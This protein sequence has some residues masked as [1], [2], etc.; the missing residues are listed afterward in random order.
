MSVYTYEDLSVGKIGYVEKTMTES[1]VNAYTGLTGDF[2]WLHVDEIRAKQG[3]FKARIVHGMFLA[4]LISNVVGNLMP[5]P[6]TCYVNQNMKFLK[7]C[8]INDTIKAQ[9]EVVEKLPRGRVKIKTTCYNQHGDI[10]L[11]GD[12]IVIPP[13]SEQA[14]NAESG[15]SS[16]G[17]E[18]VI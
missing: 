7:P 15:K 5:G 10:L 17:Q 12:A 14:A 1:D 13:K 11:D 6:G 2:N 3:R 16:M 4:G 18:R 9:A 8:Y